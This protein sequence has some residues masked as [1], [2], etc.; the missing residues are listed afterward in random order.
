MLYYDTSLETESIIIYEYNIYKHVSWLIKL[1]V[2]F[3]DVDKSYGEGFVFTV[4]CNNL[5]LYVH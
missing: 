1:S 4:E 2:G 5:N 3:N